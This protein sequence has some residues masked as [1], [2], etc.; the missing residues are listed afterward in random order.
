VS[1]DQG[2]AG[3]GSRWYFPVYEGLFRDEHPQRMGQAIWLYMWMLARAHVARRGGEFT[4]CHDDAAEDLRTERRTV[5][6]WF[7]TLQEHGY[8][9]IR[10]RRRY[11]LDVA[12]T[13]W[14]PVAEWLDSR[15]AHDQHMPGRVDRN[16]HPD[17]P[18]VDKNVHPDGLMYPRV[19]TRVDKNVQSEG[20]EG[21]RVDTRVDIRVDK[22]V[23]PY[24][25][26]ISLQ[27]YQYPS[28]SA[29]ADRPDSVSL[30]NLFHDL[31]A[32][33]AERAANRPALLRAIY[34]VCFGGAEDA[35]PDYGYL[36]RVA[37]RVGGAG[38]LAELMWLLTTRE[39]MTDPLAY[40]QQMEKGQPRGKRRGEATEL[41]TAD[42]WHEKSHA[43]GAIR[44][45][46][47]ETAE[48]DSGQGQG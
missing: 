31:K 41:P 4:Y 18:R 37:R 44:E 14:R 10:A 28:G 6:R 36:G 21:P 24:H 38:R 34:Q 43:R 17:E 20:A 7:G 3:T 1:D 5:R 13:N 48:P 12:I 19:D 47:R 29:G 32:R 26:S 2:H 25:L 45:R 9:T 15:D 42:E 16:V 46:K 23:H 40:I 39:P 33:L 8:I 27:D 30:S 11:A 35:L 22:N